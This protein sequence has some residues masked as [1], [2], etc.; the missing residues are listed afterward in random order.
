MTGHS[1]RKAAAALLAT[2]LLSATTISAQAGVS[3]ASRGATR[4][5]VTDARDAASRLATK[6]K[7]SQHSH[8]QR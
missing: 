5:A 6:P 2:A 7:T 8:F 3:Q 4:S 1:V